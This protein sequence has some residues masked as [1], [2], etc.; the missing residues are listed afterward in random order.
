[1][2]G[3]DSVYCLLRITAIDAYDDPI[4]T[5]ILMWKDWAPSGGDFHISDQTLN[6]RKELD[7]KDRKDDL[8]GFGG[9]GWGFAGGG[10]ESF[11]HFWEKNNTRRKKSIRKGGSRQVTNCKTLEPGLREK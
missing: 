9:G 8:N 5:F 7:V 6:L 2:R 1:M 10:A 11:L 4:Y 3:R